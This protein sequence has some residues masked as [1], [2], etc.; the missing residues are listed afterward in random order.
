MNSPRP[1]S[2]HAELIQRLRAKPPSYWEFGDRRT[3]LRQCL[4]ALV[5]LT[6]EAGGM[7]A[8]SVPD[9]GVHGLADQLAVLIRDAHE[10]EVSTERVDQ[11]VAGIAGSLGL[12]AAGTALR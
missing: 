9:I 2:Q 12:S 7:P 5:G 8:L 1:G 3:I 6:A 4:A 10:A 11:L